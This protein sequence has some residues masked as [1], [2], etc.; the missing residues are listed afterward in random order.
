MNEE[1]QLQRT[2]EWR[3]ENRHTLF[4]ELVIPKIE[5]QKISAQ[6]DKITDVCYHDIIR[7]ALRAGV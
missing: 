4:L 7:F 6:S 5:A 2:G 1:G 3:T